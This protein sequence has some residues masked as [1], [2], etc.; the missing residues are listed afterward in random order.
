VLPSWRN[1]LRVV[2]CPDK[3]ILLGLGK[4]L[5]RKVTHQVILPCISMPGVSAWQPALQTLEQWLDENKMGRTNV[6]VI[7]SSHFVR[8]AVMPFSSEVA[9]QAEEQA[10]AQIL[11]EDTYGDLAKQWRLKIAGGG[12]GEPHLVA[13][14]DAALLDAITKI[15]ADAS[16]RLTSVRPYLMSAFNSFRKQMQGKD[17][18]FVLAD[19]GQLI[20]LTLESE[21]F[22]DVRRMPLNGDLNDQLPNLLL[23]EILRSGRE[24]NDMPVYL[25]VA[26]RP[27]FDMTSDS[28]LSIQTLRRADRE[29]G[30]SNDDARFDMACTG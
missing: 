27:D 20:M 22:S 17:S 14:A 5:R 19:S 24:P 15:M 29:G 16:L 13:A 8:Y 21:Q 30:W 9:N 3:V 28:S 4:G 23:R 1:E 7:L 6:I 10:L 11:L 2:L 18:L 25:H 12:Y 26:E